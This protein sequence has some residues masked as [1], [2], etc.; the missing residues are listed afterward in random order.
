[1]RTVPPTRRDDPLEKTGYRIP[2][3]VAAMVRDAVGAGEAQSQNELVERA[4]RRELRAIRQRRLYEEYARAA[5][6]AAFMNE[7]SEEALAWSASVGDGF[8][9]DDA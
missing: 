5:A 3:S 1:M 4:L 2:R 9:E 7:M 6:D 8:A